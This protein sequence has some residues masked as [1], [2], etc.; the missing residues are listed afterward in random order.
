[1]LPAQE[2]MSQYQTRVAASVFHAVIFDIKV[3]V[4]KSL[5]LG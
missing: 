1:M 3:D 4:Y 2:T 5:V